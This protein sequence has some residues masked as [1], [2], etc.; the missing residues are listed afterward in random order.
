M[1]TQGNVDTDR[2]ARK[3]A[4]KL[5]VPAEKVREAANFQSKFTARAMKKG[6]FKSVRWPYFGLFHVKE[7][8]VQHLESSSGD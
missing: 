6:D 7:G 4:N 8:R 5:D 1:S 3:V 2:I